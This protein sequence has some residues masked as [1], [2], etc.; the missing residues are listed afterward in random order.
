MTR[1]RDINIAGR[2][3]Y[4]H[5]CCKILAT[6]PFVYPSTVVLGISLFYSQCPAHLILLD[7]VKEDEM[8]RACSTNGREEECI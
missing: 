2:D 4:I 3:G 6:Y 5:V 1:S 8:D 7:Q